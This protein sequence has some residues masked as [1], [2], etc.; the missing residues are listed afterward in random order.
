MKEIIKELQI[1][2]DQSLRHLE[3]LNNA[4]TALQELCPH[5][6]DDGTTAM[7]ILYQEKP[8]EGFY[9]CSICGYERKWSES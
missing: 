2:R 3:K 1:Q 4:I 5:K 6:L 8:H 9:R 7:G